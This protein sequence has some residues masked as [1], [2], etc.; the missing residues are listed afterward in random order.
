VTADHQEDCAACQT[1]GILR[2][3]HLRVQLSPPNEPWTMLRFCDLIC[4]QNWLEEEATAD[5]PVVFKQ[6][7]WIDSRAPV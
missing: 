6:E 4:L 2:A 7:S 3:P 1:G 5:D